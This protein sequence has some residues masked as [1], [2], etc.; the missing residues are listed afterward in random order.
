MLHLPQPCMGS[1]S[2]AK[3]QCSRMIRIARDT[4]I[5]LEKVFCPFLS[6]QS[7]HRCKKTRNN[8]NR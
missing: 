6:L 7:K 1:T 2:P 8:N 4:T 5:L 3:P